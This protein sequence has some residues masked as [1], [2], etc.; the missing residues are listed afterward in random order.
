M[1][2]LDYNNLKARLSRD[3]SEFRATNFAAAVAIRCPA[4]QIECVRQ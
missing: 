4:K 3:Y 2:M 1:T